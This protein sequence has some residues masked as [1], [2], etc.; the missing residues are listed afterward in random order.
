VAVVLAWGLAAR[1]TGVTGAA[2]PPD[3]SA[4]A[5]AAEVLLPVTTTGNGTALCAPALEVQS[6]GRRPIKVML[7]LSAAGGAASC[8]GPCQPVVKVECSGLIAPGTRWDFSGAFRA[9]FAAGGASLYAVGDLTLADLGVEDGSDELV[10]DALCERLFFEL[11]GDCQAL[12][13]FRSAWRAGQMWEGLP[14]GHAYG[15]PIAAAVSRGCP[16]A[17]AANPAWPVSGYSS[18]PRAALAPS[19]AGG[20]VYAL[21]DLRR[22]DAGWS[23]LIHF[24]NVGRDCASVALWF[25]A[26][27]DCGE[28]M[29]CG[30]YALGPGGSA[31]VPADACGSGAGGAGW[32][33]SD[34]PLAVVVDTAG[35][36][37][38][39]SHQGTA[40]GDGGIETEAS[41]A[42]LSGPLAYHRRQG[43]ESAV[44]V[45]N[46]SG[47]RSALARLTA[48]D[49]AGGERASAAVT[50]CPFGSHT[51]DLATWD[52]LPA[53][54]IGSLRL[55]SVPAPGAGGETETLPRLAG[56]VRLQQALGAGPIQAVAYDLLPDLGSPFEADG[57]VA[58]GLLAVP[59]MMRTDPD[60]YATELAIVNRVAWPGTTQIAV[61]LYDQNGP[62]DVLCRTLNASQATLV[63]LS[64]LAFIEAGYSGT[65]L[66]SAIVWDH[67][68]AGEDGRPQYNLVGL[69]AVAVE[70]DR[71][72]VG[73]DLTRAY[74]GVPIDADVAR[75][76]PPLPRPGC[77]AL[78]PRPTAT[79][80]VQPTL[81]PPPTATAA[82]A[83]PTPPASASPT[84]ARPPPSPTVRP[85]P[86]HLPL[87]WQCRPM[88]CPASSAARAGAAP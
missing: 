3:G 4:A 19:V 61:G 87:L 1:L 48:L 53:D 35:P 15:G 6:L 67:T 84:P 68:V 27:G 40:A 20:S 60:G 85:A 66:V 83:S 82:P 12:A 57:G 70:R 73:R 37:V 49:R 50:L 17:G 13:G 42:G 24:Q 59:R 32:L 26:E 29:A 34:Q 58:S 38:L 21:A 77:G 43:W 54:W 47:E 18:Q 23:S 80:P 78:M 63:D 45:V 74:Q 11:V 44:T 9:G 88:S 41:A 33:L 64:D 31:S 69:G 2:T 75:G 8:T 65:A 71:R 22:G 14:L 56:L 51:F 79:P 72:G 30:R 46:L 62:L 52:A 10:A 7:L 36:A 55:T 28:R 76:G 5:A 25:A 39:M 16:E 86:L 81:P